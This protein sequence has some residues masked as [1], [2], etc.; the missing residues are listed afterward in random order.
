[1]TGVTDAL[2]ETF[3]AVN[4]R[5]TMDSPVSAAEVAREGRPGAPRGSRRDKQAGSVHGCGPVQGDS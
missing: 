2:P 3:M 1:M 4:K 5:W